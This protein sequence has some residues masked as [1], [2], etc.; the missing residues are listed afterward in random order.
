M[1]RVVLDCSVTMAWCF[2]DQADAMTDRL[3]DSLDE[4][5]SLVPSIWPLEVANVLLVAER[6]GRLSAADS[7][8]YLDLLGALP[9][10][11]EDL[12][13]ARA[14]GA[15]LAAAHQTTISSYDA[16]YLELAM[17]ADASLATRDR[18]LRTAARRVGV[19]LFS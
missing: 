14:T 2:E 6:H 8:R 18:S 10:L 3:L 5:Q 13:F 15:V 7:S 9:I 17:R 11:V 19:T 16:A 12:S 1:K 4:T